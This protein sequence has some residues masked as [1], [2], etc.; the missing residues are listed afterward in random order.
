MQAVCLQHMHI[1]QDGAVHACRLKIDRS[2]TV[3][4]S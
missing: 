1:K 2:S 4:C 3:V